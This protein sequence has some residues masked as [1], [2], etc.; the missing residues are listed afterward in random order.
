L[1]AASEV[2]EFLRGLN[3]HI[4]LIPYNP[5]YSLN[6]SFLP[7][8]NETIDAFKDHL[9]AEGYKVTRRF[10]LGQDIAAACGQLAN[11]V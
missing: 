9:K 5:D 1:E 3:V 10:S 6:K 4:N 11:K 2:A 8:S 7:S